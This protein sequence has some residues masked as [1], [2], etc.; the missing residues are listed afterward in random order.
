M[1]I[2]WQQKRKTK[3]IPIDLQQQG[4]KTVCVGSEILN[5]LSTQL[6]LKLRPQEKEKIQNGITY[7]QLHSYVAIQY[8]TG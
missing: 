6:T 5:G 1:C 4:G 2:L 3:R 7:T 8:I